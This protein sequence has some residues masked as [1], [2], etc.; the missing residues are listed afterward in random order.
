VHVTS[1]NLTLDSATLTA[2]VPVKEHQLRSLRA[3]QKVQ[4]EYTWLQGTNEVHATNKLHGT[5]ERLTYAPDTG[6]LHLTDHAA[7]RVDEREGRGDEIIVDRSNQVF[8]VNH[9]AWLKLPGQTL[10]QSGFLSVS[11]SSR[12][13]AKRWIEVTSE[14]YEFHTNSAQFSERVS[15]QEHLDGK[16]RSSL[17]C[18]TMLVTFIGSTN[19]FDTLTANENV[20]IKEGE[21]KEEGRG[22]KAGHAFYTHTNSTLVLTQD[23]KWW[24][25]PRKGKGATIRVN[26]QRNEMSVQ[27]DAQLRM[28]ANQLAGQFM[29]L[30]ATNTI[31]APGTVTN[32]FA[33]V[34]CE[35]Y[36]LRPDRS[37][38]L[39]GVY[40]THPEMN[41]SCE[42][43]TVDV[44]SAG[45]T[46]LL[47]EQNVVFDVMTQK[48]EV[49]GKSDKAVYSFGFSNALA[50]A[51]SPIDELRLTGSPAFLSS[52][53]NGMSQNPVIIWDRLR[54]KVQF[55]GSDYRI[56]GFAKPIDTNIF[57]LPNKKRKK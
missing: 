27:G 51:S 29:V 18:D 10:G 12:P 53:T 41:W 48:G 45:L 4:V 36:T 15:L 50:K 54:N 2:E 30:P 57:V 13:Q 37:V 7:W 33:E 49:Q 46:N 34:F 25:G 55:P 39:G 24:D 42:K 11:N 6:L 26:T 31:R 43:L 1:T 56:Q 32:H 28:P 35:Q 8:R 23:P 9:N 44:P 40:A 20:L 17:A 16:V 5:G 21:E 19:E 22:F 47:A 3:E 38:F 14:S 52:G